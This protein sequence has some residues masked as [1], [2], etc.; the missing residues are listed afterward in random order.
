MAPSLHARHALLR[1]WRMGAALSL[2]PLS[3]HS[4]LPPLRGSQKAPPQE[5][6][7]YHQVF[8]PE[9]RYFLRR[10]THKVPSGAF[11]V[12]YLFLPISRYA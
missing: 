3:P 5:A 11:A 2:Y 6:S 1:R 12:T 10:Y 4:P 8:Y 9:I 7:A